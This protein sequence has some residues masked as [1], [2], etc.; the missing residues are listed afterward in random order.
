MTVYYE[1]ELS[2]LIGQENSLLICNHR[3]EVEMLFLMIL[4]DKLNMLNRVKSFSKKQVIYLPIFG[5]NF[6]LGETILLERNWQKDKLRIV[7]GLTKLIDYK[8]NC[9]VMLEPEGTRF[10]IKKYSDC[11][12]YAR[13]KNL[14]I[15]KHHL[16]PRYKG[17]DITLRTIKQKCESYFFKEIY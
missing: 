4:F 1:D 9:I 10:S 7:E 3:Y 2:K 6:Y 13:K 5:V 12:E 14:D 16:L 17:F 15:F 8:P 11:V